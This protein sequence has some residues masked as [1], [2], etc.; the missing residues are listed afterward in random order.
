MR[1]ALIA[2]GLVL[3]LAIPNW[4]IWQKEQLLERGDVVLLELAPVDPRS[5]IQGDYMRLDYAIARGILGTT[6]WSRDGHVVVTLSPSGVARFV[7]LHDPLVPLATGERLLQYRK[8]GS[9]IRVGSDAFFFQE[10]TARKY[11]EARYGEL[12][13]DADGGSVLVGLRDADRTPIR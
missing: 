7:R 4:A 11:A 12:R 13:V 9:R 10:G 1:T 5:L 8:R 2:A 3:S 6:S